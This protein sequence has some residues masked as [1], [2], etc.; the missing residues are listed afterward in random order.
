MAIFTNLFCPLT[1]I[2]IE[3]EILVIFFEKFSFKKIT[4]GNFS[5]DIL[6][7]NFEIKIFKIYV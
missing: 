7:E 4:N 5:D 6:Q 2:V 1:I 3:M